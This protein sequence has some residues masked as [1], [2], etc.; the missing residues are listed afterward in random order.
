M[1]LLNEA[2]PD[3]ILLMREHGE[4][5]PDPSTEIRNLEI[6]IASD[7]LKSAPI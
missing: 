3:H 5:I 4:T 6:P 2:V 1:R 7:D